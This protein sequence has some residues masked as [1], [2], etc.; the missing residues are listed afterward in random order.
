MTAFD[1]YVEGR[2]GD[3]NA[4]MQKPAPSNEVAKLWDQVGESIDRAVVARVHHRACTKNQ[5]SI[6]D[7]ELFGAS[8]AWRD[9]EAEIDSKLE[10][11]VDAA[12]DLAEKA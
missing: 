9:A 12:A 8:K 2:I 7:A 6:S 4:K 11:Y 1:E 10:Q 5:A 3:I